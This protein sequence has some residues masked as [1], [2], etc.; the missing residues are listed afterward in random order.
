MCTPFNERLGFLFDPTARPERRRSLSSVSVA[1][2][3]LG[4]AAGDSSR[5]TDTLL[6]PQLLRRV[7]LLL[8]SHSR[9]YSRECPI[10]RSK[11]VRK[12]EP[13]DNL[14]TFV[15][16]LFLVFLFFPCFYFCT[17]EKGNQQ[18]CVCCYG[19]VHEGGLKLQRWIVV[20]VHRL[21]VHV[22]KIGDPNRIHPRI[23]LL[24]FV[25]NL[26]TLPRRSTIT[27]CSCHVLLPPYLLVPLVQ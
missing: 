11:R 10:N 18:T 15:W 22:Q 24:Y 1:L 19:T 25:V 23:H 21:D 14:F 13:V 26:M 5:A 27:Y 9:L 6:Q 8:H 7:L 17:N 4:S 16:L 12:V 2:R 3:S 20:I